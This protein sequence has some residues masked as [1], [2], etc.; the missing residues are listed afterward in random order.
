MR[1]RLTYIRFYENRGNF[2]GKEG[3]GFWKLGLGLGF[4]F[5]VF[6]FEWVLVFSDRL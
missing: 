6:F 1:Y 3:R 4:V 5:G 2:L